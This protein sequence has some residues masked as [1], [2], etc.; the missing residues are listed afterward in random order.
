VILKTRTEAHLKKP[1]DVVSYVCLWDSS[2]KI[3]SGELARLP[4]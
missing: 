2:A 1:S 3:Y 4:V